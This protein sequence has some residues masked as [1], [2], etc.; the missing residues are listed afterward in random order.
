MTDHTDNELHPPAQ[1]DHLLWSAARRGAPSSEKQNSDSVE[2]PIS[3]NLLRAYQEGNL[4]AEE[5]RRLE[6][7]LSHDS[8]MRSR[9]IALAGVELDAPPPELRA[10]LLGEKFE[11]APQTKVLGGAHRFG[12]VF[13]TRRLAVAATFLFALIG[14]V[15]LLRQ[16]SLEPLPA[17]L[18]YELS[19]Q[20]LAEVRSADSPDRLEALPHTTVSLTASPTGDTMAGLEFGL[21]VESEGTLLR[22]GFDE[23]VTLDVRRG[24]AEVSGR[25]ADLLAPLGGAEPGT[26]ALVFAVGRAGA[27]PEDGASISEAD[28]PA[29]RLLRRDLVILP[30]G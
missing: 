20:G 3:D 7:R 9:L 16:S 13:T 28:D 22:V 25:A 8:E 14:S 5:N 24:T 1:L 15:F 2:D 29:L 11:Q 27:L 23:K 17:D 6:R 10:R 18:Q 4:P 19:A 12:G 21:Y 30:E 26:Y